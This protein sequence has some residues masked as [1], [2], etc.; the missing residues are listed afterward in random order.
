VSNGT[1]EQRS[2]TT[3]YSI[4]TV[5]DRLDVSPDTVRRLIERGELTA[6]RIGS[7]IR[8]DAAELE[9]FLERQRRRPFDATSDRSR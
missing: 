8:V 3:L 7:N 1:H 5:A 2:G 9:A 6:I 4:S